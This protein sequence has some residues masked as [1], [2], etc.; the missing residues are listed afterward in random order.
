[1]RR[2][3]RASIALGAGVALAG[4]V[5]TL[6]G[7][8]P[9]LVE[10]R[11]NVVH[12]R[13]A[14]VPTA[15]ARELHKSLF[16][17]DLH[18]DS[19]LWGRDLLRRGSRGHVDV[20]RL[21]EG[22]VALQGF[23]ATTQMPLRPSLEHNV[24]RTDGVL[25][26][27][28]A[29]RWPRVTW[30]SRL[31]RAIRIAD[32]AKSLAAASNGRFT[33]IRS[34]EELDGYLVRRRSVGMITAGFLALEGAHGLDG[35]PANVDVLA[36]AGYRMLG[37]AHFFDNAFGGSAHGVGRIGLTTL[38]REVVA[39][40]EAG[41]I[42]VDLAHASAATIDDTLGIAS[43]PVVASHTGARGV[44]DNS[45]NLADDQLRG[46]AATGGVVGIG[47]WPTAVGGKDAA[48]IAR[49]IA[50]VA[51][52]IGIEH[53]ALG[54]DWDGA[55]PVPFD[56]AG[57]VQLTDALLIEG[58]SR[59]DIARVMGRNVLQLMLKTL[60]RS[61]QGVGAQIGDSSSSPVSPMGS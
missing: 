42:V 24:D 35:D 46:I 20:P 57:I 5:A 16:V 45:R 19:L 29:Q 51:G 2:P 9:A 27:A 49:T 58:L 52:L 14:A 21:I 3:T 39:R 4:S 36:R 38:G 41:S 40:A 43:R 11:L 37:I 56:A 32:R 23:A 22:G 6:L 15:R 55:V 7:V 53:L 61:D 26:L 1:V 31:G 33:L 28:L 60:P 8:G 12:R 30:T 44:V 17:A 25:L 50:Y 34:G 47:F 13:S 48:S 59:D 54:S 18:A 10:L